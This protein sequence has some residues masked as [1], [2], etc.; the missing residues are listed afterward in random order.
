MVRIAQSFGK[1]AVTAV[2]YL[3]APVPSSTTKIPDAE[4]KSLQN[5]SPGSP[6]KIKFEKFKI[7]V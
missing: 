6:R 3:S 2:R 4:I 5:N 1:T 7:K